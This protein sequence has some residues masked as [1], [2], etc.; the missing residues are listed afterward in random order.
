MKNSLAISVLC[1]LVLASVSWDPAVA[2]LAGGKGSLL[3]WDT[4]LPALC[5]AAES[6][7]PRGLALLGA[8]LR[9]GDGVP[10]DYAAA[11]D[12]LQRSA[13]AGDPVGLVQL[14]ALVESGRAAPRDSALAASLYTRALPAL[15]EAAEQ[16]DPEAMVGLAD[17]Y[18]WGDAVAEDQEEASHWYRKAAATDHSRA[19]YLWGYR[20]YYGSGVD[21]DPASGRLLLARAASRGNAAAAHLLGNLCA[22]GDA[23]APS[24]PDR[25]ESFYRLAESGPRPTEA[26]TPQG[27]RYAGIGAPG[28]Q[29]VGGHQ[30]PPFRME[31]AEGSCG[32]A[33][34]WSVLAARGVVATQHAINRAGGAPGRGLHAYELD[35]VLEHFGIA[36]EPNFR[37]QASFAGPYLRTWTRDL[38]RRAPPGAER[39]EP[40]LSEI[41]GEL[42][43]GRPVLVGVKIHPDRHPDWPCDHFLLLVGHNDDT[44]EILYNDFNERK[45]MPAAEL[46]ESEKGYSLVNRYGVFYRIYFR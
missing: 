15:H 14:A 21:P 38:F 17:R 23:A 25:A 8:R 18:A 20:V 11:R 5:A 2:R 39:W 43:A 35:D 6:G 16:G 30:P 24:E 42:R 19:L 37:S 3:G 4:P 31:I 7:D 12:C 46:L 32:E 34:L 10:K 13:D 1:I 9:L 36:C 27:Y 41:L 28:D 45:R 33:C 44:G 22:A 26:F 29:A 40:C